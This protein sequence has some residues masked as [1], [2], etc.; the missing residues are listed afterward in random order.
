MQ[1]IFSVEE[2]K[3]MSNSISSMK[4]SCLEFYKPF[5]LKEGLNYFKNDKKCKSDKF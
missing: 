5:F 2:D 4:I 3:Y 1:T